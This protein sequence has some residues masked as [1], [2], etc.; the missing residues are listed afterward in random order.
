[1]TYCTLSMSSPD[2]LDCIDL[3]INVRRSSVQTAGSPR[4]I[5]RRRIESPSKSS[6][7]PPGSPPVKRYEPVFEPL[8]PGQ[9]STVK[10]ARSEVPA[11]PN[12]L[13]TESNAEAALRAE[14]GALVP[15]DAVDEDVDDE[16]TEPED[17]S[18][19]MPAIAPEEP[20]PDHPLE[21][22]VAMKSPVSAE[23][24][25]MKEESV[26]E[27]AGKADRAD[28]PSEATTAPGLLETAPTTIE[29]T[30]TTHAADEGDDSAI[31]LGTAAEQGQ[32]DPRVS[33]VPAPDATLVEDMTREV[34]QE[35]AQSMS[36][37]P[38]AVQPEAVPDENE[39]SLVSL[40]Q[41]AGGEKPG[42]DAVLINDSAVA[43]DVEGEEELDPKVRPDPDTI[44]DPKD[45]AA[46][47]GASSPAKSTPSMKPKKSSKPKPKSKVA[48]VKARERAGSSLAPSDV[49]SSEKEGEE[50]LCLCRKK[51]D[52]EDEE[53]IM[54]ACDGG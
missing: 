39:Q 18:V 30:I 25:S 29:H 43:H 54:V 46:P 20:S 13:I 14:P 41:S 16:A 35:T 42:G 51:F 5:K 10:D 38:I 28:A 48:E 50:L 53:G 11:T 12:E 3:P 27:T 19:D 17:Y 6:D 44:T 31:Q 7:L 45:S 22:D 21:E 26:D 47:S 4:E 1:M 40:E 15:D 49:T 9:V 37:P 24:T 8:A 34:K 52:E 36:E 33:P 2:P 32:A 23:D